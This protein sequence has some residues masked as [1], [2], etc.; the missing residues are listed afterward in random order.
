MIRAAGYALSAIVACIFYVSWIAVTVAGPGFLWDRLIAALFFSVF[1]GFAA[2]LVFTILPW[3]LVVWIFHV[4]RLQGAAYFA[5]TGTLA[6][7]V[8]GCIASAISP[9]PLF[10][11]DHTFLQ[12]VSTALARQGLCLAL[13]G[14][15]MGLAYWFFA[16]RRFT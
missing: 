1:G 7:I 5:C 6:M 8:F 16:E 3:I 2:A 11:E 13:A 12:G 4:A 9:E 10:V 14:T 15:I